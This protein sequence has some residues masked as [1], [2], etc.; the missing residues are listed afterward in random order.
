[1]RLWLRWVTAGL[2]LAIAALVAVMGFARLGDG[3]LGPFPGGA[4]RGE[5]VEHGAPDWARVAQHETVELQVDPAHP[6]SVLTCILRHEGRPYVSLTLAP[7]KRW[8]HAVAADSRV[9]LRAEG[10]LYARHLEPVRDPALHAALKAAAWEKY[11]SYEFGDGWAGR[12]LRFFEV[13]VGDTAAP[14]P[15]APPHTSDRGAARD[16]GARFRG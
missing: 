16:R 14:A 1:M 4:L 3:P 10:A 5:V 11:R 12:N 9:V 2:A 8:Q 13:T 15:K 7:L 6:R